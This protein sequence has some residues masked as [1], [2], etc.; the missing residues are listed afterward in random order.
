M[1]RL[2]SVISAVTGNDALKSMEKQRFPRTKSSS[3]RS[4]QKLTDKYI[5]DVDVL[6]EAKT[7]EIMTV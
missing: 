1:A 7:K 5:K 6:M 3:L 4:V 2:Q